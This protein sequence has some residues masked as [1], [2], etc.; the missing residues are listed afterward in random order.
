MTVA[1]KPKRAFKKSPSRP[2][3]GDGQD[4]DG[5]SVG[6]LGGLRQPPDF[7]DKPYAARLTAALPA[8]VD[9]RPAMPSVY[10]Q[11]QLYSCAAN[12]TAAAMEYE[13]DRQGLSD[14][15]PSR[16][17]IWYNGRALEGSVASN[18]GVYNRDAIKVLN[19]NGVCPETMWTYDPGMFTITPPK[20]C[21]VTALT[22]RAVSYEAIST[23]GGL[24]DAVASKLTVVFTLSLYESFY[25]PEVQQTGVVPMPAEDERHIGFH[26]VLA[27]GYSDPNGQVI[28]RNSWAASW[29]DNGY[30]YLPYEYLTGPTAS[31]ESAPIDGAYLTAD[32]WSIELVSS[33]SEPM[34]SS[35]A[36]RACA[37]TP[38]IPGRNG[39]GTFGAAGQ[40]RGRGTTAGRWWRPQQTPRQDQR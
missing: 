26:S 15:V 25:S 20:S 7:R 28:V 8:E 17:F 27:V 23:L 30:F 32:F 16:L 5:S 22:D 13:R 12:S 9:L 11:G 19:T 10:S 18:V 24:K 4:H 35:Y 1:Q 33:S 38:N 34:A 14:C 40:L 31:S 39:P 37:S 36:Y 21:Y 3:R 2:A 29:G 6:G